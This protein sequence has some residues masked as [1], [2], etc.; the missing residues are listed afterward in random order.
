MP[1]TK[2][3]S[4]V[5]RTQENI[6]LNPPAM[7]LSIVTLT[8]CLFLLGLSFVIH[9]G[10]REV[11][12]TWLLTPSAVVYL[13]TQSSVQELEALAQEL[14]KWPKVHDLR[15]V[16]KEEAR[17]RF[18]TQLGQW[19]GILDGL[20][21]NPLPA[22]LEI[23]F[24]G[25]TRNLE[26]LEGLLN[27]IREFPQVEEVFHGNTPMEKLQFM[28]S[29]F[30]VSGTWGPVVLTLLAILTVFNSVRRTLSVCKEELHIYGLIGATVLFAR[31]PFY[32][33]G[34][35]QGVLGGLSAA[36]LLIALL[37]WA[38]EAMPLPLAMVLTWKTWEI[39]LLA[40]VVLFC[41]A[42]LS[43]VGAWLALRRSQ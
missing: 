43:W 1:G 8:A 20:R 30:Q 18:D 23:N 36:A 14:R 13:R 31:M 3:H 12:P 7:T 17:S 38:R 41:G 40:S 32:L 11:L 2:F 27:K 16:S 6:G 26:D 10:L 29:F 34:L 42:S 9:R 37:V 28:V 39:S 5:R 4:C 33:V 21:D 22:S 15:I 35:F 24:K 25:P 19:K